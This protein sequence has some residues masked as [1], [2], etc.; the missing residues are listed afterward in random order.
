MRPDQKHRRHGE[1]NQK[2]R[3]ALEVGLAERIGDADQEAANEGAAQ[4]AHAADD[5]D[6]EGRD[7]DFGIHPGIESDHWRRGDA[8]KRRQCHA[9]AENAGE[10]RRDVGAEA[11]GHDGI[12]DAGTHHGADAAALQKQPQQQ[13]DREAEA[14]QTQPVRG[15]HAEPDLHG[16]L[17]R[18][19]YR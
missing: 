16:A 15:K 1:I 5:D 10:Q 12:V 8:A 11:G 19:R 14:D 17:E 7:E 13:R 3:D 18:V 9:E 6:D 4:A 2:Q